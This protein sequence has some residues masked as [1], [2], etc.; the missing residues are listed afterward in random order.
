[1][2]PLLPAVILLGLGLLFTLVA[3]A[4]WVAANKDTL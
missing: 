3:I 2:N 1:M 4:C